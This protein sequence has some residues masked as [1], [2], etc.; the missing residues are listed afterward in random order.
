MLVCHLLG[1][2]ALWIR[3]LSL[4][5]TLSLDSLVVVWQVLQA[6]AELL[7]VLNSLPV[8]GLIQALF[9]SG[10]IY[11]LFKWPSHREKQS[12]NRKFFFAFLVAGPR[13]ILGWAT[14]AHA[15][16]PRALRG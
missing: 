1:F 16:N 3:W 5:H 13:N 10:L 9:S 14:V 15:C 12:H 4:P 8:S 6:W 7:I 11:R 2:L